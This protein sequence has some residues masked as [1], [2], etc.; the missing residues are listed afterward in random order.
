[1]KKGTKVCQA[2]TIWLRLD[3][4]FSQ[5][6]RSIWIE[7]RRTSSTNKGAK[8]TMHFLISPGDL[9]KKKRRKLEFVYNLP[10]LSAL[11]G[12]GPLHMNGLTC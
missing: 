1:M 12:A 8:W 2:S 3:R 9:T 5:K 7:G 4:T 10:D 6:T 11:G